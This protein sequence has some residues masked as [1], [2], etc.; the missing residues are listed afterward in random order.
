MQCSLCQRCAIKMALSRLL[1]NI[2]VVLSTTA[3]KLDNM[4][5]DCQ[6]NSRVTVSWIECSPYI[7]LAQNS[8]HNTTVVEAKGKRSF[9][10]ILNTCLQI[11]QSFFRVQIFVKND[12]FFCLDSARLSTFRVYIKVGNIYFHFCNAFLGCTMA[13]NLCFQEKFGIQN[14]FVFVQ[15]HFLFVRRP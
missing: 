7:H 9:F 5:K 2:V 13:C 1:L 11:K 10:Y 6:I 4:H 14:H 12:L 3:I 8:I 15:N